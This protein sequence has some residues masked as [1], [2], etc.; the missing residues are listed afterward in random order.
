MIALVHAENRY[1]KVHPIPIYAKGTHPDS[2]PRLHSQWP[3]EYFAVIEEGDLESAAH[4]RVFMD[5][6][7]APVGMLRVQKQE[8]GSLIAFHLSHA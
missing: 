6:R 2:I 5:G 1:G 3:E 8:N 4:I 7:E